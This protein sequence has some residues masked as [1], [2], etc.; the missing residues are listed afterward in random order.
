[1]VRGTVDIG[2]DFLVL[3]CLTRRSQ[4]LREGA[5]VLRAKRRDKDSLV[6]ESSGDEKCP[7]SEPS[8]STDAAA[9][10]K[11]DETPLINGEDNAAEK[12]EPIVIRPSARMLRRRTVDPITL[13]MLTAS[14]RDLYLTGFLPPN[15]TLSKSEQQPDHTAQLNEHNT[16]Q[17]HPVVG[18]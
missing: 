5:P 17:E 7:S 3:P 18:V 12:E 13:D 1:M 14:E 4:A 11:E 16:G 15:A 8:S 10:E 9:K 6:T 2:E